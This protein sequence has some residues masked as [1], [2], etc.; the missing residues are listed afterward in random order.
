MR[1]NN[2]RRCSVSDKSLGN[3]A[4]T[5]SHALSNIC[6]PMMK[7]SSPERAMILSRTIR[8]MSGGVSVN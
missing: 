3:D 1:L 7:R 8:S 6:A 5:I 2:N 4:F